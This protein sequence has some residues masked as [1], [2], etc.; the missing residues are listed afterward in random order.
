MK[1][2]GPFPG[3][4]KFQQFG[5]H[6]HPLLRVDGLHVIDALTDNS[7]LNPQLAVKPAHIAPLQSQAFTDSQA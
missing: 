3:F 4:E 5:I 1:L 2:C 6:A 7:A